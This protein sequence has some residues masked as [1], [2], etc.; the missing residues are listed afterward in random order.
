M[1]GRAGPAAEV[2]PETEGLV[3]VRRGNVGGA[4]VHRPDE[5]SAGFDPLREFGRRG[6]RGVLQGR[7]M[8]PS[9]A[10]AASATAAS[11]PAAI[12]YP[13]VERLKITSTSDV[14]VGLHTTP[15]SL[16]VP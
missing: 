16:A 13:V 2:Y 10:A 11:A 3:T 7:D 15:A 4:E 6:A 5:T 14:P 1:R 9:T 12:G 8:A